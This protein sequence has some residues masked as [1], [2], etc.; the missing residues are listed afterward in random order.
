[1]LTIKSIKE[2]I[3]KVWRF[4]KFKTAIRACVFFLIASV[5]TL[6]FKWPKLPPEL[7]LYYSLPWGEEQ[8]AT[9]I[10]LLILPF[11]S[12]SVFFLNF[13]L[14]SILLE[15]APWLCR[16]L[17]LISTIFAFLSMV[18]LIKIVFLIS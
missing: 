4:E 6:I 8:L 13:F 5:L 2:K 10:Q 1:M 18:T 14:A 12:L 16:I 17:I 11:I 15:K 3:F 7:P 9:P